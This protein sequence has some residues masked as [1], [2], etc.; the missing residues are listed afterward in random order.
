MSLAPFSAR[1]RRGG[2]LARRPGIGWD[3]AREIDELNE[4][5]GQLIRSVFGETGF[6]APLSL[7]TLGAPID[8]EETDEAYVVDIDLPSVDPS[9]VDLEM[10]GEEL[11]IT[12]RYAQRERGGVVRRQNR[13]SGEFEYVVDLPG[14]IDSE[15]VEAQYDSGVLTI[16][17][18]KARGAQPR[19]IE[20]GRGQGGRQPG[21]QTG[22]QK[23]AGE[24]TS[25]L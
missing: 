13:Q 11:R 6:T 18:G 22:E 3:P 21:K 12:G 4:R 10:R 15:R 24:Q 14:D 7:T 2:Q 16:T 19:R 17:V 25:K 1:Q 8:I 20:I 23:Q 5:F 9:D